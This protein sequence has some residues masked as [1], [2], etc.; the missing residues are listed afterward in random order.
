MTTQ[1][2]TQTQTQTLPRAETGLAG[3]GL[4]MIAGVF[5]LA[6]AGYAQAAVVHDA[7]HDQRHAIAFP[8]H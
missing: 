6:I 8:C 3:I 1:T 2:Q 5:L 7:A 4:A